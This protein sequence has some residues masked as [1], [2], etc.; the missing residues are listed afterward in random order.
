MNRRAISPR[1]ALER[2][3]ELCGRSEHCT[4]EIT[5]K[6]YTWGIGSDDSEKI[7]RILKRDRYIDDR[8]FTGAFV[9]DKFIFNHWGRLKIRASL[10]AKRIDRDMADSVIEE[11]ISPEAYEAALIA[12][13]RSRSRAIG[14][15]PADRDSM[16][17][18]IRWAL[19]RGYESAAVI[20]AVKDRRL[21]DDDTDKE[22]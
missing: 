9:R 4:A 22:P 21:W 3:R 12:L 17:R 7:I 16:T 11:E 1:Q 8:R 6:L 19:A 2:L 10:A 13:L 18:L 5:R 15:D 14:A 20:R